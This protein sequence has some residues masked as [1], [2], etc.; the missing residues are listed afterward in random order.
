MQIKAIILHMLTGVPS[1]LLTLSA[2]KLLFNTPA[3]CAKEHF[4][5]TLKEALCTWDYGYK[6]NKLSPNYTVEF[7]F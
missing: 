7:N 4:V 3:Y 1:S 6:D 5:D 2:L